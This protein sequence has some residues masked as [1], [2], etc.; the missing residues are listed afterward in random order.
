MK[1]VI[2]EAAFLPGEREAA[3]A[4]FA[5][6]ADTVRTMD[7]CER[8]TIH[9]SVDDDGGIAIV[10]HWRSMEGFDAYRGSETFATLAQGLKPKMTAPPSTL[11]ADVDS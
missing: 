8:Y 7:G 10:Q 4:L 3:I 2:V 9:R 5:D 1:L 11:V 6:Q